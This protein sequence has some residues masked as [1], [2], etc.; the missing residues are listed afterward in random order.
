MNIVAID[1]SAEYGSIAL[2][3]ASGKI[4]EEF[5]MH[6]PDGFG[7]I[8]FANIGCLLERHGLRAGDIDCF[9]SATGPGSFT[10]VRIGLTAAKGLAESTGRR[11]AGVS[12]LRAIAFYG[13][14]H[15]RA[16]VLD[17]RRGDVYVALYDAGLRLLDSERVMP[18]A[19]WLNGLPA[20][21]DIEFVSQDFA[22]FEAALVDT[23]FASSL[24]TIASRSLAGAIGVI[25]ARDA[26]ML[27][28]AALDANYVRRS[29]AEHFWKEA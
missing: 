25:A 26:L 19:A 8:L 3:T 20:D 29:D 9:A 6:S 27:D 12:N 13:Q 11:V 5:P 23:R 28:P 22:P 1:T 21:E 16:V 18:V 2:V 7:H 17:A 10:G 14:T 15:R 24:V 4:A